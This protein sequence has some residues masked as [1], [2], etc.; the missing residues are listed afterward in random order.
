MR[1]LIVAQAV[2]ERDPALGFFIR[3]IEALSAKFDS[4]EVVCLKEGE[5]RLPENV[6]VHSLGKERGAPSPTGGFARRLRYVFRFL[7]LAR[8]LRA[9]YDAVLVFQNEEYPLIAGLLWLA[10]GKP[11]YLWRNH[12]AGTWRT[13]LAVSLCRKVFYTSHFSYTARFKR[14]VRMPVGVD[15]AVFA[16]RAGIARDERSILFFARMAPSKR[17]HAL[18]DALELLAGWGVD[19]RAVFAGD[20]LPRD[21]AYHDDL[22]KRAEKEFGGRVAF[23][24]GVPHKEAPRIFGSSGIFVN[25]SGSGMYDKTLFE[26]AAAGCL[27]LASSKDFAEYADPRCIFKEGDTSDL[28]GKLSVLLSLSADERAEIRTGLRAFAQKNDVTRFAER[29]AEEISV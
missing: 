9:R 21:K 23:V 19:F 5:H 15:T 26:A 24:P 17:P 14:A 28:A 22:K 20:S 25:L 4:L 13:T 8:R 2:D 7:S 10:L 6:A 12:Y 11:L 1:L 18:L 27:V 29:L 3:W 16:P